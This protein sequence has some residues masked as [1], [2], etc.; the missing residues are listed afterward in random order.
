MSDEII[1]ETKLESVDTLPAWSWFCRRCQRLQYAEATGKD[2]GPP[3]VV[4]CRNCHHLAA[5]KTKE[6]P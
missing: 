5:T 4:R 3:G 1:D 2:G 6:S